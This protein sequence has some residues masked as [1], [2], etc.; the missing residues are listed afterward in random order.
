VKKI[1]DFGFNIYSQFGEDGIIEKIFQII[2]IQSNVCIEFGAWDGIYL[3]NTANLWK[4]GWKGIL[5]ESNRERFNTLVQNVKG[6][7]C[8]CIN[9]FV[10]PEGQNTLE[11]I[12]L[13]HKLPQNID[14]LS[15]DVDGDDYYI[16]ESLTTLKPR[17]I[18]CEYNPT[19]PVHINLI[20]EKNN[21]FG[22]SARSLVKLAES[23]QFRL[24]SLTESNCFFVPEENFYKFVD[25]ETKLENLAINK[26]LT[27][28]FTGYDGQY[29]LSNVPT[30]GC[31]I[32]SDLRFEGDYYRYNLNKIISRKRIKRTLIK[33]IWKLR[34]GR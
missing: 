10:K 7:D 32:S 24:V 13:R 1:S 21:N 34:R 4:N 28:L 29:I 17:V 27:Y 23:K 8:Y 18:S 11:N 3:S 30:Y 9:E 15:I 6:K 31:S 14:F 20:P 25:Y 12:L 5:I 22:C 26:H 16:F 19:I 33:L 2:G